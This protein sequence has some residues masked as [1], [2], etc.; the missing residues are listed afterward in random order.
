MYKLLIADDEMIEREAIHYFVKES[1]LDI[2]LIIECSTG[3]ETV[4]QVMLEKP[5]IILLDINMPGLDG[6]EVLERIQM[7]DYNCKV[8]FS[9]AFNY[10]EYVLKALK[11]GAMD[12]IVKPVKKE[13]LVKII[14]KAI[15][16]LDD[17]LEK[18]CQSE[19]MQTM[20]DYMGK[21][22]MG[23]LICGNISQEV[24]YYLETVDI[25]TESC[26][27]NCF[28]LSIQSKLSETEKEDILKTIHRDLSLIGFNLLSNWKNS[29]LTLIIIKGKDMNNDK[30]YDLMKEV[31][32]NILKRFSL[33]YMAGIGQVFEELLQIEESYKR[34]RTMIG[35]IT[36]IEVS[37][38]QDIENIP[39]CIHKICKFIEENYSQKISLDDLAKLVGY[40]KYHM[41]RLFKEYIGTTIGDYIIKIRMGKARDLLKNETYSIKKISH[42]V[43]YSEANYFT[44]TFKKIEGM[45]PVKFRYFED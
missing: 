25:E 39:L 20:I 29:M 16:Q 32:F 12:F 43:G 18:Q 7:P 6:L 1:N 41:N 2:D 45:S 34:A 9:T 14:N 13:A 26:S 3:T 22:I 24:L 15:D 21:R 19:R 33:D 10:F 8:I 11:L 27:G 30:V 44:W 17:E 31:L 37:E 23:E 5:D 35:G 38:T 40:S 4:K 42:M 28:C 36:N